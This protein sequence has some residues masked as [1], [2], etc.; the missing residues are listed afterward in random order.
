VTERQDPS[1]R[2]LLIDDETLVRAAIRLLL[3]SWPGFN[4]VGEAESP[5]EAIGL[6]KSCPTDIILLT[7]QGQ[8]NEGLNAVGALTRALEGARVLVLA[9]E[10]E[11]DIEIRA[12]RFGARG[13]LSRQKG[14]QELRKA[15]Q[16]VHSGE[17]WLGRMALTSMIAEGLERLGRGDGPAHVHMDVLSPREREVTHLVAKGLTNR[18]IGEQLSISEATVRHH[19]TA[20]FN[21]LA[22]SNRFELIAHVYQ[23]PSAN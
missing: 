13:V 22:I 5:E 15:V 17:F 9:R 1:I 21:K 18:E 6:G 2:I 12:I 20:I 3:E 16:K 23:R 14:P 19:L 7:V 10:T 4:V 8:V 11:P